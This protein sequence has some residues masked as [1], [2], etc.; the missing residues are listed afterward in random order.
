MH[1]L[2]IIALAPIFAL[3]LIATWLEYGR[4][5]MIDTSREIRQMFLES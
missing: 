2:Y 4:E 3:A 1:K 5:A